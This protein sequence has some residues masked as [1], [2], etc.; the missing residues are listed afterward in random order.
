MKQSLNK[1]K[2][3]F[4][5]FIIIGSCA[6]LIIYFAYTFFRKS[7]YITITLKVG[8]DLVNAY[9]PTSKHWYTHYFYIGMKEKDGFG[10]PT[11]EVLQIR[12]YDISDSKSLYATVKI[13]SVY[14]RN[15]NQYTFRGKPLLIGS[16]LQ[17]YLDNLLVNGLITNIE[18]AKDS[19]TRKKFIVET[20]LMGDSTVFPETSGVKP[21]LAEA[22]PEGLEIKGDQGN[23]EVKVIKK[24]VEN[25]KKIVTTGDGKILVQDDPLKKDV[26]FTLEVN[27]LELHGRYFV[28]DDLPLL[29]GWGIPLNTS[30]VALAPD[31]TSIIPN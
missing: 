1:P 13:L 9:G 29:V 12:S 16:P 27:A 3:S 24:K 10:K 18:G 30:T 15:S 22:I 7:T 31:V 21:Y 23:V 8:L 19:R 17:L 4:F 25:A 5:T 26:Y 28:F 6:L 20:Q 14:N 2:I 11:A